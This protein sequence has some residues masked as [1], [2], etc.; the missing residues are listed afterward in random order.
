MAIKKG[1]QDFFNEPDYADSGWGKYFIE[2]TDSGRIDAFLKT[3]DCSR[4]IE[5]D[6]SSY[7]Y[8]Q[9]KHLDDESK[10][11]EIEKAKSDYQHLEYKLHAFR[12]FSQSFVSDMEDA[13][14]I[15]GENI[16]H[17][18]ANEPNA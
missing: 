8:P 14:K 9:S 18:E 3:A 11:K 15:F 10:K 1:R 4:S 5:L 17:W 12:D 13:L 16:K 7:C 2:I 6:F